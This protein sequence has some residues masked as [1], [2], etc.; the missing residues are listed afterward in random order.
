[1]LQSSAAFAKNVRIH[2][3]SHAKNDASLGLATNCC[4]NSGVNKRIGRSSRY[5]PFCLSVSVSEQDTFP[6][7]T[8]HLKTMSL[9][10]LSVMPLAT[11]PP[12]LPIMAAAAMEAVPETMMDPRLCG[13]LS[14]SDTVF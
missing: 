1:M 9:S 2:N 4:P 3:T 8:T 11:A 10:L 13:I 14:L 12:S 5:A 7:S 6:Q